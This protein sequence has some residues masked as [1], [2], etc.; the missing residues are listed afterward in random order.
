VEREPSIA[1][2]TYFT[3]PTVEVLGRQQLDNCV[4]SRIVARTSETP[5]GTV[6]VA[7]GPIELKS[8]EIA[9]I[10]VGDDLHLVL[11]WQIDEPVDES[12]TVFTQLLNAEGTLVAQQD[13]VPVEGLAPTNSWKPGALIRDPYRLSLPADLAAGSYQLS[14]GMYDAEGRQTITLPDGTQTDH[15]SFPIQIDRK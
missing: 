9:S 15:M 7:G 14:I 4:L 5:R 1:A 3:R 6:A 13:N 11:Y 12:Y 10:E 8:I 2:Q